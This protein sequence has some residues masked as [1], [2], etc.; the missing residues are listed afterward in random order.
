[1]HAQATMKQINGSTTGSPS[2]LLK[3]QKVENYLIENQARPNSLAKKCD[4]LSAFKINPVFS[5]G[6]S[7]S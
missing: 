6:E 2:P 5:M 7:Q 3:N 1:M 4:E